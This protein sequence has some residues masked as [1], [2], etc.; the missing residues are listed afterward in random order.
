MFISNMSKLAE[1]E[2]RINIKVQDMLKW[3]IIIKKLFKSS[4]QCK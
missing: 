4:A 1:Q 3:N 2:N